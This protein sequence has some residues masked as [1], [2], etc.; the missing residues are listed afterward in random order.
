MPNMLF[1]RESERAQAT[2]KDDYFVMFSYIFGEQGE[3]LRVHLFEGFQNKI[4]NKEVFIV[5]IQ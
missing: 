1:A 5:V 3:M 2:R 4:K